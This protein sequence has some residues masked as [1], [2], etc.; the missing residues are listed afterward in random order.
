MSPTTTGGS[1]I[2]A[3]SEDD[4]AVAAGKAGERNGCAERQAD[5][6][7]EGDGREADDERQPHDRQQRRIGGEHQFEGRRAS[8]RH[9]ALA[10]VA[11][12]PKRQIS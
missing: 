2:S 3:L 5:E 4:D 1:P 12:Q 10:L 6:G 9:T 11:F 7:G 8:V